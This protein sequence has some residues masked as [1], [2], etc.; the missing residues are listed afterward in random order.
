M[1]S[2]IEIPLSKRKNIL[3]LLGATLFTILGYMF[4]M[5]PEIFISIRHRNEYL[6]QVIGVLATAFFGFA[7]MYGVVKLFDKKAGLIIDNKGIIDN[8]NATSIGLILWEDIISIEKV[9]KA[10]QRFLIIHTVNPERYIQ[11]AKGQIGKIA[12]RANYKLYKS[13]ISIIA[14]S[15]KID[16]DDLE[17]ILQRE[18]EKKKRCL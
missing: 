14:H 15:L 6:M 3:M 11:K 13:P 8:T 18:F 16:F 17:M 1:S 9:T 7:A 4:V 10:S 12:M 2:K 5:Q